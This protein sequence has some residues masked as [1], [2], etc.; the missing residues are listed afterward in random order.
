MYRAM[1]V[2]VVAV[3]MVQVAVHEVINVVSVRHGFVAAART[4]LVP[5]L[6]LAASVIGSAVRGIRAGDR[7][8]VLLDAA[9]G[10]VVQMAVVEVIDVALVLDG[11]VAAIQAVVVRVSLVMRAHARPPSWLSGADPVASSSA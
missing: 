1:I 9:L 11:G 10:P 8:L 7:Q 2:A 6:M 3:R 5:L 4:M